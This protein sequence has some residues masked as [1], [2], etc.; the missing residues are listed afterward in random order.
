MQQDYRKRIHS[1]NLMY[2]PLQRVSFFPDH[3]P[4]PPH[5]LAEVPSRTYPAVTQ[6]NLQ[7]W[8][9]VLL[10]EHES[11]DTAPL[12]GGASALQFIT[13]WEQKKIRIKTKVAKL[14]IPQEVW[15]PSRT[16]TSLGVNIDSYKMETFSRKIDQTLKKTLN[17]VSDN[18]LYSNFSVFGCPLN[19]LSRVMYKR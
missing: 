12:E 1:N 7:V 11:G 16:L 19:T 14:F 3:F 18:S 6:E 17:Q 5:T 13:V 8:E 15:N 4:S 10:D 2:V 9:Y